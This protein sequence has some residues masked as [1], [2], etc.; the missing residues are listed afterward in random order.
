MGSRCT[1]EGGRKEG[2]GVGGLV[3]IYL[4]LENSMFSNQ[5]IDLSNVGFAW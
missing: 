3:G 1:E 2:W 5:F 4:K